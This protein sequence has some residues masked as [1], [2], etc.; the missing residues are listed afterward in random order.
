MENPTT[1][2]AFVIDENFYYRTFSEDKIF[3]MMSNMGQLLTV[4]DVVDSMKVNFKMHVKG[5]DVLIF[6]NFMN[7]IILKHKQSFNSIVLRTAGSSYLEFTKK[8]IKKFENI[9]QKL[10]WK[11]S[12]TD[13]TIFLGSIWMSRYTH[14]LP[15]IVTDDSGLLVGCNLISSLIGYKVYFLSGHELI[16][17][18]KDG[19]NIKELSNCSDLALE[20]IDNLDKYRQSDL[21]QK[22]NKYIEKCHLSFHPRPSKNKPKSI[23]QK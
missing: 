18:I 14:Y 12:T 10:S 7:A 3:A 5:K 4:D 1:N 21:E 2:L 20:D 15:F 9:L 19:I 11:L 17:L 13:L 22:I 8:N 6:Q 16:S 23:F